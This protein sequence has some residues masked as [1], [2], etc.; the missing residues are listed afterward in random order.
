MPGR[1]HLL[2]CDFSRITFTGEISKIAMGKVVDR[3]KE[4][5]QMKA[6]QSQGYHLIVA[7]GVTE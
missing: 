2:S 7:A 4:A 5:M 3:R 6:L 1:D